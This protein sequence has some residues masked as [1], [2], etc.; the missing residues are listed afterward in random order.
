VRHP[1]VID[2]AP[3]RASIPLVGDADDMNGNRLRTWALTFCAVL[4]RASIAAQPTTLI[5][6]HNANLR[7][8]HSTQSTIK[9]RLEPG[10]AGG[11]S[12]VAAVVAS[13]ASAR[14]G[15]LRWC[16]C[17]TGRHVSSCVA[18]PSASR[19]ARGLEEVPSRRAR[20][21][22]DNS[23]SSITCLRERDWCWTSFNF[24]RLGGCS[25]SRSAAFQSDSFHHEVHMTH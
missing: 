4:L 11:A 12:A 19:V 13:R 23:E 15:G 22:S 7:A 1:R 16:R 6:H 8:D 25:L 3:I 20:W 10:C 21:P 2:R 18:L 9:D 5:V 17:A 24:L 14:A